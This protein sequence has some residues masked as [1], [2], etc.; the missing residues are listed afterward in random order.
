MRIDQKQR[1][2]SLLGWPLLLLLQPLVR[3][4]GKVARRDHSTAPRGEIA[5]VKMLGGGSL[6]LAF[7]ALLG[8]RRRH[9]RLPLT[10]ICGAGVRP[11]AEALA[12]FD[13]IEVIDD[14]GGF[15]RL[16]VGGARA[17]ARLVGRRV[18]TA[19][20]LEVYSVLST[21]FTSLTGARNRIGFYLE[22]TQWRRNVHTH[23]VFFN[24][25]AGVWHFYDAMARLLGAAPASVEE[26]RAHLARRL[27]PAEGASRALA[28]LGGRPFTAVGAGCSDLGTVRQMPVEEWRAFARARG[29]QAS[30]RPWVFLGGVSDRAVSEEVARALVAELGAERFS[31]AN[32][33]GELALEDSLA[34]L[35]R[36]RGF[37]GIDSAL[38]HAAR[39]LG[40]PSVSFWGATAPVTRLRPIA[41]LEEIVHYRPPI[42][43]PCI[44]VAEEPPCK[45]DNVC[46][47]LFT[48]DT[49][50]LA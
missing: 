28:A 40:I 22:N 41:G 48:R 45:G 30:P 38:L 6:L 34:V 1:L 49:P 36:A 18:D 39:L 11:F 4:A 10:I 37:V 42:C 29:E 44:H 16:A 26:C 31:S 20:D 21:V 9:P 5:V 23:L 46:M 2:D 19:L 33:C 50:P 7:P 3:L 24:R 14:G 12:I 13:R 35:A 17:L 15:S 8:L 43:S 32:L 27:E 25:S 47:W